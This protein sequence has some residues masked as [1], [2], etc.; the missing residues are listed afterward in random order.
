MLWATTHWKRLVNGAFVF[1]PPAVQALADEEAALD[2]AALASTLRSIYPLRYALVDRA[3]LS[4][5]EAAVWAG[6]D[7]EPRAGVT[8]VGQLGEDAVFAVAGDWASLSTE[9]TRLLRV[10]RPDRED[11]PA[12]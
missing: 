5:A 10:E 8:L 12:Q 6:L 11:P 1:V 9:N 4:P 3:G 7:G 2:A